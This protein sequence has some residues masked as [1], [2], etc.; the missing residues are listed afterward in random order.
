MRPRRTEVMNHGDN[1]RVPR[2]RLHLAYEGTDFHGWQRQDPPDGEP[3]RTVQAVVEGAVSTVLG[4]PTVV[5]GASRTDAGVHARDQVAAFSAETR[6]PIER[7]A[8]AITSRLPADVQVRS[9]HRAPA[10]FDPSIHCASKGYRYRIRDGVGADA[11][12]P[13]FDRRTIWFTFHRLDVE[14]MRRAAPAIEGEH[15]FRAMTRADHGRESTVRRV[16]ACRV[17]RTSD[18]DVEID[19]S[20]P[21]FL[22][23]MVRI[24]AGTLVEVG[25]GRLAPAAVSAILASGDRALAG[26]TLPPHGLCLEWIHLDAPWRCE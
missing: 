3:L 10:G 2:Y 21:G 8:Q 7:M 5:Q 9:A 22:Y 16:H 4:A 19:V 14:A 13:L 15:D 24:I 18:H 17:R 12:V 25:R 26:P 23:N 1:V 20:G 6:I 11:P